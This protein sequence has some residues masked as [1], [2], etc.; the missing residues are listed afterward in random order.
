[1]QHSHTAPAEAVE[2]FNAPEYLRLLAEAHPEHAPELIRVYAR[3][4]ELSLE[5]DAAVEKI[6]QLVSQRDALQTV[7]S[8]VT[9]VLRAAIGGAL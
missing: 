2:Q 8:S 3:H 7:L 4:C 5:R 6:A 1:M 9:E